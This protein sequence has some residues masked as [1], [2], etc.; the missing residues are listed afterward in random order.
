M[1]NITYFGY[2]AFVI[3]TG[4]VKLVID[5]GASLYLPHRLKPIIPPARC[6]G[7]THVLVTHGDPDHHWH[8]DRV[9]KETGAMV[10]CGADM[11]R[12]E[13][14]EARMLGPRDRGLAFTLS[15]PRLRTVRIG[16]TIDAEGVLVTGY[17]GRHGPLPVRLGPFEFKLKPGPG[18]RL[19]HGE[20]VFELAIGPYR[21]VVF[22][23]T[24]LMPGAWDCIIGPDLAL[25]P[26]GG[27]PTMTADEAANVV[28]AMRPRLVIPCHYDCPALFRRAYN[29]VDPDPFAASVVA[30]GS[31]CAALRPAESA[32]LEA[33]SATTQADV[34]TSDLGRSA[35]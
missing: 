17:P 9:A 30:A 18:E 20:M 2:N 23:D 6:A 24:V 12:G 28:A 10:I 15:L 35:P 27:E 3:E 29:P 16:E 22:G 19:G 13:G 1:M 21:I 33:K 34:T 8:T 5:P 14:R 26:I 11:V 32:R 7:A 25:I 31:G 4:T